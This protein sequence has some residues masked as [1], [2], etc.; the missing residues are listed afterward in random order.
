[1]KA[2]YLVYAWWQYALQEPFW[3]SVP[4]WPKLVLNQ[5]TE[6]NLSVYWHLTIGSKLAETSSQKGIPKNFLE[7]TSGL[8]L[9]QMV[10]HDKETHLYKGHKRDERFLNKKGI[11][12][13]C[14]LFNA[15]L[16]LTVFSFIK[17]GLT[18][19]MQTN[20]SS[21]HPHL[22][23]DPLNHINN[24]KR[25]Q[26][27]FPLYPFSYILIKSMSYQLPFDYYHFCHFRCSLKHNRRWWL[28][29]IDLCVGF[30][31]DL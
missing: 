4:L 23:H 19:T 27:T 1:M 9:F 3:T 13:P 2:I 31:Y 7:G 11:G 20:L 16:F 18:R 25:N 17:D 6:S 5:W 15:N 28:I 30:V 26:S 12:H 24:N 10:C 22:H 21:I 8:K 14:S 29:F